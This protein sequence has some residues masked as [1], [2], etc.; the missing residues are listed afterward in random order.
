MLEV[1]ISRHEIITAS[2]P[3][4]NKLEMY[5]EYAVTFDPNFIFDSYVGYK[6]VFKLLDDTNPIK[7]NNKK[8]F[9]NPIDDVQDVVGCLTFHQIYVRKCS[10]IYCRIMPADSLFDGEL[11][12]YTDVDTLV[13]NRIF[14]DTVTNHSTGSCLK[15]IITDDVMNIKKQ[16]FIM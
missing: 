1:D 10:I 11:N 8:W 15:Y 6:R 4:P 7:S 9:I 12:G 13:K 5:R 3:L 14:V 2:L 16:S